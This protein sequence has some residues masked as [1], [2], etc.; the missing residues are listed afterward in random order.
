MSTNCKSVQK[1]FT[2]IELM[3]VVAIIGILASLAVPAYQDYTARAQV[4]EAFSLAGAQKLAV[5]EYHSSM[6][7]FPENNTRAGINDNIKGKYVASI[8][9]GKDGDK[10]TITATMGDNGVASGL[11]EAGKNTLVFKGE[12]KDGA[13][14]WECSNKGSGTTINEK[15]LP[16]VCRS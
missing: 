11:K 13:Y 14:T 12:F 5:T 6:G 16:S 1:G 15:Y 3:I 10:A 9:I 4:T 7:E 8:K 2:L